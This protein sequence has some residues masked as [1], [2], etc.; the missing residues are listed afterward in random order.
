[1]QKARPDESENSWRTGLISL[2]VL[3]KSNQNHLQWGHRLRIISQ[4]PITTLDTAR[5]WGGME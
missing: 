3:L 1:M 5:G 4:K 2:G